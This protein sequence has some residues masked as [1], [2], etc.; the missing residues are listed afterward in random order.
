MPFDGKS[1]LKNVIVSVCLNLVCVFMHTL[2][3]PRFA[4]GRLA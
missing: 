1:I 3:Q 4:T 2:S